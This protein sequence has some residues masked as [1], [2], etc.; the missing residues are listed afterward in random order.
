MGYINKEFT[1]RMIELAKIEDVIGDFVKLERNG[2]NFKG[3]SPFGKEKTPSFVVSPVKQIFKDFHSGKGGNV[4]SFLMEK[5]PPMSYPEAVEYIAKKYNETVDYDTSNTSAAYLEKQKKKEEIR[6]I[7]KLVHEK[8]IAQYKILKENHPARFEVEDKRKYDIDTIIEWGI[9]F[10]PQ[11]FLY[12]ILK[13]SGRVQ[14]GK[15]LGLLINSPNNVY[16]KYSDRVI[17][18][19]HN[20]NGLLIGFAGRDITGRAKKAKWINPEGNILYQKSEVLYA[21]HKAKAQIKKRDE[22]WVVEGY[23]D[24]IAW[25]NHDMENTVSASG[26]ALSDIHITAI[27]K[28]CSRI[29]LCFD[30]DEAG[31]KAMRLLIPRLIKAGFRV[32]LVFLPCDPDDFVREHKR[33]VEHYGLPELLNEDSVRKDGF[34]FLIE[35]IIKGNDL[36]KSAGAREMCKMIATIEDD[37]IVEIYKLWI[38]KESGVKAVTLKN[39]IK[40][41]KENNIEVVAPT[42]ESLQYQLPYDVKVP[43]SELEDDIKRYGLFMANNQIYMTLPQS[44]DN[45]TR[46]YSVSNFTI[47]VLQHM[48]DE[49]FP[50]KLF[51]MKNIHG[52]ECIFDAPSESI[53][54]PQLFDNMITGHGNY[55]FDGARTE[56]L[57]LKAFLMDKMGVGRKIDV[58][59]WQPDGKFWSW[60]NKVTSES[61]DDIPMSKHGVFQVGKTHYYVPSANEIYLNNPFKFDAQ[62]RFCNYPNTVSFE[63]FAMKVLQVHRDH[64]ISSILFAMSSIFQDIVVAK[65]ANFPILFYYGPGSSGKDELASIVQSFVGIPQTAINLEG[66]VSTI[67]AQ[68][69]EFAQFRNGIS[70]LSEYKNGNPQ[71]D[72]MLKA[73][74]DRRGYKRGNIESHVGTDSI[75][76]ESSAILTGNDFP[77]E[78]PLILRLIWNEMTKVDF[79]TEE[80]Q[81]FD[82]LKDMRMKGV[83]G[84]SNDFFKYRK[85]YEESFESEQRSWKGILKEQ[86]PD[87]KPRIISNLSIL[88]TTYGF[89]REKVKFPWTQDEMMEH[90]RK[91][92]GQQIR[93]INSAS[94]L[95]RFW[96]CFLISLR[97]PANQRIQEGQIV[98]VEGNSLYMNMSHVYGKIQME[99][100]NRYREMAPIKPTIVEQ[101][102]SSGAYIDYHK[103]HTFLAGKKE[104]GGIRSSA[105]EINLLQLPE[106]LRTDILSALVF[107]KN[108]GSLFPQTP[109]TVASEV[110]VQTAI[111]MDDFKEDDDHFI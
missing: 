5:D 12:D 44:A 46:F 70:Q 53:N 9:G 54:S 80:M 11:N 4:I 104:N 50:M 48:R 3:L 65:L 107:Q 71:L 92:I 39:W 105:D 24:A 23:N 6:P 30:P 98:N 66:N 35:N 26:T 69:R 45:K 79:S 99:W 96:E 37:S 27:K 17:Y 41:F 33:S 90:F 22:A 10:A 102:K 25:H 28:L 8:Y 78:E 13:N 74:W 87:A 18:P 52:E 76:I 94:I 55:R 19:I 95:N 103:S 75:P 36:D 38:Q 61:G 97:G 49:K 34:A 64:A 63:S 7:L 20:H 32:D 68:V 14:E 88:T 21:M 67:K 60:N 77:R 91:G 86:F 43:F 16:D 57:K 62:K 85:Q 101:I 1:E 111:D 58:L 31:I 81:A 82:E 56:L 72:G 110:N 47:E 106:E 2:S 83:S 73:L 93:K 89:F 51:R 42:F 29:V 108:Q 100:F 109:Q 59:G 15:E 84:Y 40:E